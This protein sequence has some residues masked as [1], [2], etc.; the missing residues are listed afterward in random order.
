MIDYEIVNVDMIKSTEAHSRKAIEQYL[1]D[2]TKTQLHKDNVLNVL[3]M[4]GWRS[5]I[6]YIEIGS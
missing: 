4:L 6:T 3:E 5:A 2:P 1:N